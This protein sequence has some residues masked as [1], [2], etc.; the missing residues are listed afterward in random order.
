M[1]GQVVGDTRGHVRGDKG[2]DNPLVEG[3]PLSAVVSEPQPEPEYEVAWSQSLY[4][5]GKVAG[6]SNWQGETT[7]ATAMRTCAFKPL[8]LGKVSAK[9]ESSSAGANPLP[10]SKI[11]AMGRQTTPDPVSDDCDR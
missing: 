1:R 5:E 9:P 7:A 8:R 4:R 11:Q 6:L 10:P 3:C 2:Q